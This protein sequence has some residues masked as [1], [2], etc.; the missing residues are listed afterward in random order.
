MHQ[1][2]LSNSVWTLGEQT[3]LENVFNNI[4][5]GA[6]ASE[7]LTYRELLCVDSTKAAE[8]KKTLPCF[9]V[10]GLFEQNRTLGC[11]KNYNQLIHLDY[12]LKDEGKAI[13]VIRVVNEIPYTYCSFISP[14]FGV[15]IFVKTGSA[16]ENHADYFNRLSKFYDTKIG[17]TSDTQVKDITRLC[18]ISHDPNL[19]L[20]KNSIVFNI[21]RGEDLL[22]KLWDFTSSVK[23]YVEGSRNTFIHLYACNASRWGV[24]EN[25]TYNYLANK[26]CDLSER[27]VLQTISSAYKLTVPEYGKFAPLTNSSNTSIGGNEYVTDTSANHR[28]ASYEFNSEDSPMISEENYSKLPPILRE[29]CEQ[30]TGREKDVFLTG[31]I[32]ALSS[33]MHNVTGVY[34]SG[35]VYPNLFS[36][37]T[38]PAASGKSSIKYSKEILRCYHETIKSS[39]QFGDQIF[40]IPANNS[41]SKIYQM[42]EMNGGKGLIF[43]TEADTLSSSMKQEWGS[44]SD[45]LRKAF[46]NEFISQARRQNDEYFEVNE[47]KFS[48]CLTGTNEQVRRLIPSTEDGLFSRFLFYTF[49]SDF[50]WKNTLMDLEPTKHLYFNSLNEKICNLLS[51]SIDR[52]F[53]VTQSQG[54][55]FNYCFEELTEQIKASYP[56]AIDQVKRA[57]LKVYKMA[58][59]L[60]GFRY[61]NTDMVCEDDDFEFALDVV[62]KIYLPHQIN[63]MKRM[64]GSGK[65]LT[66]ADYLLERVPQE[67][68][69]YDVSDV[70]R[71]GT[72]KPS[73]KTISNYL[74]QLLEQDKI[75]KL[76][77]GKYKKRL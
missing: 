19:Y 24:V 8:Y 23:T 15:K 27:E 40:F 20:N 71:S 62:T 4:T 57:G 17:V 1:I 44:F 28:L 55:K 59:T 65:Q 75:F 36:F 74:N 33:A 61:P 39:S 60:S 43:E 72:E 49:N 7:I 70:Y 64:Y 6:Y 25:E 12:D 11:L 76:A 18:F 46:H 34:D 3:N 22:D 14:T 26:C 73:D 69:R 63:I 54:E 51:N 42:L 5:E 53:S 10:S 31:L 35:I 38:A 50:K 45:V 29:A 68:N 9:T 52:K 48:I 13:E 56:I 66:G 21:T 37:V 30:F 67:F 58:M 16:I 2:N 47:P 41:A 77:K 32:T